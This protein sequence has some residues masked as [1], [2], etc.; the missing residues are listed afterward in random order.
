MD[1]LYFIFHLNIRFGL[2]QGFPFYPAL[3]ESSMLAPGLP[4]IIKFIK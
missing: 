1:S 3:P 2:G 4:A